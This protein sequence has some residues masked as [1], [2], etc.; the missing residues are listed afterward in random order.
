MTIEE[1]TFV[2]PA[3]HVLYDTLRSKLLD[4]CPDTTIRVMKT[5]I[6]FQAKYGYAFVSLPRR[7]SE[8]GGLIVS[9]GLGRRAEHPRIRMAVEPYPGR[10]T[11]H[12]LCMRPAEID[13]QMMSWL[14]EVYAFGQRK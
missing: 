14:T 3:A 6:T 12:T 8:A 7:K 5:Q 4:A 1:L 10:W 11:H 13:E 2:P 9:F